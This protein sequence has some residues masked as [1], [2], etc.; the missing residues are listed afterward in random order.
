MRL[1]RDGSMVLFCSLVA[2]L[3]ARGADSPLTTD[4]APPN[5]EKCS[6]TTSGARRLPPISIFGDPAPSW[7]AF[8]TPGMVVTTPGSMSAILGYV[9]NDL[10]AH[11]LALPAGID[12]YGKLTAGSVGNQ[13]FG[14]YGLG[15][16]DADAGTAIGGEFTAR[17]FAGMPET[18]LPPDERVGTAV[19]SVVGL[20]VTAGGTYNSSIA[21]QIGSEGGSSAEFNTGVYLRRR[22]HAQYGIYVEP[23][24]SGSQISEYLGNNGSGTNLVLKTSRAMSPNKPVV[25]VV[26]RAG[27]GHFSVTQNGDISG[28][29]HFYS[30]G[31]TPVVRSCGASPEVAGHDDAGA[32]TVGGGGVRA[33]TLTFSSPYRTVPYCIAIPSS[34]MTLWVSAV[35]TVAF[36]VNSSTSLDRQVLYYNCRA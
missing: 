31:A 22:S 18:N 2:S 3:I 35:S 27:V 6:V 8:G 24:A 13:V 5:S 4:N 34:N 36:T 30:I 11:T 32:I 1:L 10:P 17:N 20:Q 12:G 9:H 7:K 14:V 26:D 29:G 33:C 28:S 15:E 25:E 19:R 16:L 21:V 23:Q